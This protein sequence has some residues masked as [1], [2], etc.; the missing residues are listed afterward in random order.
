MSPVRRILVLAIRAIGDVV[1]IT[2]ALRLLKHKFP[3]AYLAVL[4]DGVSA[5]ILEHNPHVDQLF[6]ID[7]SHSHHLR[8]TERLKEWCQLVSKLRQERFDTAVDLFSGPRSAVIAWTCGAHE[9]YGEDFRTAG[10]GFLYT[11]PI[12]VNRDGRHLVEQKCDLIRPLVGEVKRDHTY[13]EVHLTE[14]DRQQVQPFL[15]QVTRKPRRLIGLVPSSG[16]VFRNWP[17]DRFAELGDRLAIEY[18]AD[19]LLLGGKDDLSVCQHVSESMTW[20]PLNL[21]GKTTLRDLIAV[22]AE[23]DL[24]ISNVTGP[25]HIAVA[26]QKP[27]VIAL[28]G[29]ADTVQY[30]PWGLT[31]TMMTKWPS[32]H[33]YWKK[34]DYHRD[35][36]RLLQITVEDVLE[37]VRKLMG[38]WSNDGQLG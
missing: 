19:I 14:S 13:L 29:A 5:K 23:L 24:V 11:H 21:S 27:I 16:S 37:T 2:P 4:V 38:Q 3:A 36:E 30:A 6:V 26:L 10:R 9:R 33:A 12:R 17:A 1:L 8:W 20:K 32:S 34:V 31:A 7:R 15:A 35:Y 25:M 18:N 28:Y 22:L